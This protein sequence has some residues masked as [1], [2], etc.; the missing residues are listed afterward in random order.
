MWNERTQRRES[1]S[2]NVRGLWL[3][4]GYSRREREESIPLW[5]YNQLENETGG[6]ASCTRK[7]HHK[8]RRKT[9]FVQLERGYNGIYKM[10]WSRRER[11]R[12]G[13][14]WEWN[15]LPLASEEEA[16]YWVLV[17]LPMT[18]MNGWREREKIEEWAMKHDR[19]SL[20]V[21]QLLRY[22]GGTADISSRSSEQSENRDEEGRDTIKISKKCTQFRVQST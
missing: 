18:I 10:M 11:E 20:F 17:H 16:E 2:W 15:N 4:H 14:K 13:E 19:L 12:E 1:R 5:R 6:G 9:R 8:W 7:I 22:G 21:Q 3:V